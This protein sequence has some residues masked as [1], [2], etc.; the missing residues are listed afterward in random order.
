M[1]SYLS[2]SDLVLSD[3]ILPYLI[4]SYLFLSRPLGEDLTPPLPRVFS[5]IVLPFIVLFYLVL[6]VKPPGV[7]S[8]R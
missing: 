7:L 8:E 3:H 1:L 6:S 4:V 2:V 5:C